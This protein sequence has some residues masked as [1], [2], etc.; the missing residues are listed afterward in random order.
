V[1]RLEKIQ[2]VYHPSRGGA[3]V[4]ALRRI[5][6]SIE[7]QE[8]IAI[9]GPS[10]SGK[11]TLLHILSLLDRPTY[12]RYLLEG[13]DVSMLSDSQR[14]R[15]R[16]RKFGFVFQSFHLIPQL[17]V[18]ANVETPLLYA[19]IPRTQRRQQ[20]AEVVDRV[21]LSHR[22]HH[23]PWELSGGEMQ[24]VAIARALVNNPL[25]ILADEP[26]GN[27]DSKSGAEI[28]GPFQQLNNSGKTILVVTHNPEVS[29]AARR[30]LRIKDGEVTGA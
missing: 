19:G 9:T 5:D 11:S 23:R 14:A 17:D 2:K 15:L 8:F 25:L 7:P 18:Q 13:E 4:H 28:V 10:G 22:L 6:L 20:V 26:T 3:E 24:R 12:G 29:G 30:V 21:G 1:I 16:N 27:L